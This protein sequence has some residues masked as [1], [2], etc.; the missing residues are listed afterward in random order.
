MKK[1]ILLFTVF[2]SFFGLQAQES[3]DKEQHRERIKAMKVAYITQEMTMNPEL[4][5]KFWPIYNK[6]MCQKMDLHRREYKELKNIESLSE[7][8]AEKMLREYQEIENEEYQ[9]KKTLFT[10]LKK[11][12]SSKEIIKLHQLESDFNKKLLKEYRER[13]AEER[14]N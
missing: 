8:E 7:K 5:Q 1:L 14:K 6:Y 4:A 11:I 12:I 2:L 9:I 10:D 13:K 3:Y